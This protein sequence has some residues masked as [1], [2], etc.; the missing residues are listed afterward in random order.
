MARG[1][2]RRDNADR[3]HRRRGEHAGGAKLVARRTG[4]THLAVPGMPATGEMARRR[5]TREKRHS[6]VDQPYWGRP[7]PG[8]G[9]RYPRLLIVGLAPAANGANR[10]G[11][12]F[13]GDRSGDWLFGSLYRVGLATHPTSEHAGDGQQLAGVR[14]IATLR[15]APPDNKPT[16]VE[17]DTCSPWS[18]AE[19]RSVLPTVRVVVALGQFGWDAALRTVRELGGAAPAPKPRF[20]HGARVEL[21]VPSAQPSSVQPITLLGC[22]HPSQHNT[23]TGRLTAPMLDQALGSARDLA[24]L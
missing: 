18:L 10:T 6:F 21:Q 2:S 15:C 4:R 16:V 9:D 11:R 23:F 14:M 17:R 24:G 3:A 8:W 5:R 19:W 20:A 7:I 12:M 13:T 22:Y 1:C